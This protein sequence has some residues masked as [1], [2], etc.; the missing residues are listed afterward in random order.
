M[1]LSRWDAL[2]ALAYQQFKAEGRGVLMV[3]MPRAPVAFGGQVQVELDYLAKGGP[4]W[5][6]IPPAV[7]TFV[8]RYDPAR[9]VVVGVVSPTDSV[10]FALFDVPEGRLSPAAAFL[11]GHAAHRLS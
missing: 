9:A 7:E 5:G 1:I 6:E 11:A 8:D 10:D 4:R 3:I 2:A